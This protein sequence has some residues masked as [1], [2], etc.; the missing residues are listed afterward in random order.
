MYKTKKICKGYMLIVFFVLSFSA[1]NS[2]DMVE[3]H[4]YNENK[5][6]TNQ[7]N[8]IKN[9]GKN[10]DE[11][12]EGQNV[13][14]RYKDIDYINTGYKGIVEYILEDDK[15]QGVYFDY[16][17]SDNEDI[18]NLKNAFTDILDAMKNKY[19]EPSILA[20]TVRKGEGLETMENLDYDI[21]RPY[22]YTVQWFNEEEEKRERLIS[23]ILYGEI[24]GITVSY[25]KMPK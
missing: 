23:L 17:F 12:I 2:K 15:L 21:E 18:E 24:E 7:K 20:T 6:N 10:P 22:Y 19:G 1:C 16:G 9:E 11:I 3:N 14:L 8:I 4:Y 13:L 5:W 25:E